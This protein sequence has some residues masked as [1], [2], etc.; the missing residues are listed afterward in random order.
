MAVREFVGM[1]VVPI[2]GRIGE[3][4]F[5]W[6]GGAYEHLTIVMTDGGDTYISR[7]TVPAGTQLT[8]THYWAKFADF[9]AQFAL[10]QQTVET[11]SARINT[12]QATADGA[13][14]R[15]DI[16]DDTIAD[17]QAILAGFNESKTVESEI[18]RIDDEIDSVRESVSTGLADVNQEMDDLSTDTDARFLAV[19]SALDTVNKDIDVSNIVDTLYG[20]IKCRDVS[21]SSYLY[22]N[23]IAPT[24]SAIQG[25]CYTKGGRYAGLF[26]PSLQYYREHNTS[27]LNACVL[28]EFNADGTLYR[29]SQPLNVGH[30]NCVTYNA[31]SDELV[32]ATNYYLNS[33]T[34]ER[35]ASS[36]IMVFDYVTLA[37][38]HTYDYSSYLTGTANGVSYDEY[39][40]TL[41]VFDGD[42]FKGIY[43]NPETYEY[44]SS[45][46]LSCFRHIYQETFSPFDTSRRQS[47]QHTEDYIIFAFYMPNMFVFATREAV[48]R[49]MKI[50]HNHDE[51]SYELEDFDVDG[52]GNILYAA[53]KRYY[54]RNT[55]QEVVMNMFT[56]YESNVY[57]NGY[58][59]DWADGSA[60]S[61]ARAISVNP[62]T[63]NVIQN[64]SVACP[65]KSVMEAYFLYGARHN[66]AEP[67]QIRIPDD[68]TGKVKFVRMTEGNVTIDCNSEQVEFVANARFTHGK[69]ILDRVNF[70]DDSSPDC[71]KYPFSENGDVSFVYSMVWL[72]ECSL[73]DGARAIELNNDV[74]IGSNNIAVNPRNHYLYNAPGQSSIAN[75]FG[76]PV[77]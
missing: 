62:N 52:D 7:C 53:H 71:V 76:G 31:K 4:S 28:K 25:C 47:I 17:L 61:A 9:N 68:A 20:K 48:P 26:A 8:D 6:D 38:R 54:T 69:Y 3:E 34:F 29:Q 35:E 40:D 77:A 23:P 12:A 60:V 21:E 55:E 66:A 13:V 42:D 74:Y 2:I 33:S 65:C 64:G 5:V 59:F 18:A 57:T 39:T 72:I 49:I 56:I 15:I 19:S 75:G 51:F 73:Y 70:V 14:T 16:I 36:T 63:T 11:Y 46:D 43:V 22:S 67:L 1:R 32:I 41:M 45:V 27:Y 50:V 44:I 24:W 58:P 37:L 10:L 30:G